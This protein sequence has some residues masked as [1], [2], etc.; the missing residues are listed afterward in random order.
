[1]KKPWLVFVAGG[2]ALAGIGGGEGPARAD[3]GGLPCRTAEVQF[4]PGAS[5]M[6]IAIWVET[7]AGDFVDTVYV[8][9]LT[10]QFGLGNRPGTP[11]MK[12]SFRWP[13]GRREMVLPVWAH[14]R[15]KKYPKVVMGGKC[16]GAD[17]NSPIAMCGQGGGMCMGDCED[18]TIAYHSRVS[19]Y[20]PFYCSP[21][22]GTCP[23]GGQGCSLDVM[24]CASKGTFSKGAYATGWNEMNPDASTVFSYYPP[25]AD[26]TNSI[27]AFDSD[28]AANFAKRSDLVVVS[29][30][31]PPANAMVQ[32]I[33]WLPAS[34]VADGDYVMWIEMSQESDFNASYPAC[35]SGNPPRPGGPCNVPDTVGTWDFEGHPFLGQPSVLYR[36]PFSLNGSPFTGK[37]TQYAGYGSWDGSDG[38]LRSPDS[39]I[40]ADTA[41]T[42]AG[43]LLAMDAASGTRMTVNVGGCMVLDGG[44]T[45]DGGLLPD[46]SPCKSDTECQTGKCAGGYCMPRCVAPDAVTS[47]T[48]KSESNDIAISWNGP[49]GGA[50]PA[51]YVVKY[52]EGDA[53]ITDATF[54]TELAPN[55]PPPAPGSPGANV[56]TTLRGLQAMTTYTVAVRG[57]ALCGAGGP[58]SSATAT[59]TVQQFATLHGCFVATAAYGH[60]ED[61]SVLVLR[62]FRDRTLLVSPAGRAF[63]ALYY[64]FSPPLADVI[65]GVPL[66]REG[67][68]ALLAP[69]VKLLH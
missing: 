28:D 36:V 19:S 34:T 24:S 16:N 50:P 39:T 3:A 25:R 13:Y 63:V 59:T 56:T 41:G 5:D 53:P 23:G 17:V 66:L 48:A 10:G 44:T 49:K 26:L 31:T 21:S 37:A 68:R 51:S 42:G 40:T 33:T 58:V 4:I 14:R 20:E 60:P 64:A 8:T 2:I 62:A 45:M 57:M 6:Q 18:S 11:L 43:R 30:A 65:A 27:G 46:G 61:N 15:N 54:A 38:L 69:L 52:H 29:Q 35:T 7:T 67:A 22:G 12:T 55:D 47:F 9:R 1:M 32:P